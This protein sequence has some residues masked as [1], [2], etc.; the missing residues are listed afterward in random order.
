MLNVVLQFELMVAAAGVEWTLDSRRHASYDDLADSNV[1]VVRYSAVESAAD[2]L[3]M[4]L[5]AL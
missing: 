5:I 3:E 4:Q 1:T 2:R